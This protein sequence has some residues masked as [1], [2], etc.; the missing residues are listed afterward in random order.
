MPL[1]AGGWVFVDEHTFGFQVQKF[2][3]T[4]VAQEQ[5]FSPITDEDERVMRNCELV[6]VCPDGDFSANWQEG[7]FAALIRL[8][9]IS[10]VAHATSLTSRSLRVCGHTG[11]TLIVA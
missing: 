3:I 1:L 8:S 5:C 7:V 11:E 6:K 2:F 9:M 10:T 4:R